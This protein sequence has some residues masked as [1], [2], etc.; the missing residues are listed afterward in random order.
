M[1][2][3]GS[4]TSTLTNSTVSSNTA[5]SGGGIYNNGASLTL[6]RTNTFFNNVPENCVGVVGC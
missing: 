2:L 4:T 3:A 1:Y 6:S 5:S